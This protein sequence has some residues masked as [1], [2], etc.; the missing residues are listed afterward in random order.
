MFALQVIVQ[1]IENTLDLIKVSVLGRLQ[2]LGAEL[3]EPSSL[4]KVWTLARHLDVESFLDVVF[5]WRGGIV[6]VVVVVCLLRVFDDRAGVLKGNTS[7]G[8][9][10]GGNSTVDID[11][12]E[13]GFL[14][15]LIPIE[16][17][18]MCLE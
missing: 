2:L 6:E 14:R 17:L 8:V 3:S 18:A 13:G 11:L 7:D 1:N 10:N 5:V 4:A 15:S 12:L 9:F 16:L